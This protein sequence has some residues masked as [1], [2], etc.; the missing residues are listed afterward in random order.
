MTESRNNSNSTRTIIG[1]QQQEQREPY[2]NYN[3]YN[4]RARAR[5][6]LPGKEA[7]GLIAEA[8]RANI[9][10]TIT[11]AAATIIEEALTHG[12][13]TDTVIMAIEETGLA[14][15]PSPYYLRA[16]LRNWAEN[17]V[18]M[19]RITGEIRT[20]EGTPWWKTKKY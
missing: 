8:Y 18:V 11:R 1:Q 3:N 15:R 7:M 9:S 5:K 6:E 13:E 2:N 12:M 19:S 17:G 10:E 14:S 16:V 20:T 4:T